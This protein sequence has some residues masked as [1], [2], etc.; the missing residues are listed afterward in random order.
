MQIYEDTNI[1]GHLPIEISRASSFTVQLTSTNYRR[2]P[3]IQ[4]GFE[5]PAKVIVTMPGTVR[6][7]LL[8]EK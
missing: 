6:N 5:I 3:F 2:S 7:H 8:L 1:V 4:G